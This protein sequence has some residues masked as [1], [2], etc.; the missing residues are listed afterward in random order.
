MAQRY[1]DQ[2]LRLTYAFN[3]AE[4]VRAYRKAQAIDPDC[5]ICY[6]GE[7]FALGANINAPMEEG[8]VQPAFQA[9]TEAKARAAKASEHE[10][11]LIEALAFRYAEQADADPLALA[12][13]YAEEMKAVQAQFPEDQDIAVLTADAIM[14]TT[15][16]D[17][18]ELDGRTPKADTDVGKA[19]AAIE[20]VLEANPDHPGAIHLYI[21][22]MEA[23]TQP[24]RAEP[25][26]DR[27][28]AL[29]PGAGHIVHMP[30]HIYIRVGR[31]LDSIEI[32]RVAVEADEAYIE[33][34]KAEGFYLESYYP[35]NIHFVLQSAQL[36]GDAE[37]AY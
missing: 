18:W 25:H 11:A 29:M 30:S 16:W 12:V 15:A 3:H 9:L 4:A 24:E 34:A 28:A 14:N 17:Y 35:H 36:A 2:G 31:H 10:R 5:A 7:A 27:L 22:L 6:W 21:H 23:S 20:G 19:I 26:A 37:S 33:R 1:F 32:N 13:D 8:A